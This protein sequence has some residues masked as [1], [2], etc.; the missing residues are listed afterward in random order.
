MLDH[1]HTRHACPEALAAWRQGVREHGALATG[2]VAKPGA[3]WQS[4]L[5]CGAGRCS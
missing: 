2:Y 3:P 4:A 5:V 1:L